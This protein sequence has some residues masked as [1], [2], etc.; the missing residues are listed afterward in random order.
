MDEEDDGRGRALPPAAAAALALA[1]VVLTEARREGRHELMPTSPSKSRSDDAGSVSSSVADEKELVR[2]RM[3]GKPE[4]MVGDSARV[5]RGPPSASSPEEVAS[6]A[7]EDDAGE[8]A[9]ERSLSFSADRDGLCRNRPELD[10]FRASH[11]AVTAGGRDWEWGWECGEGDGEGVDPSLYDVRERGG[12]E[13]GPSLLDVD[14]DD[15]DDGAGA[16][17]PTAESDCM[18]GGVDG[19]LGR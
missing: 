9:Q 4:A 14:D 3:P 13:G 16:G 17:P 7:W 10:G 15:A 5:S 11:S 2:V 1:M 12:E 6:G 18:L 8:D 19:I